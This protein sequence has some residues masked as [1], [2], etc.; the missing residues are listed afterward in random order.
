[1]PAKNATSYCIPCQTRRLDQIWPVEIY[2]N[3]AVI[4]QM[5]TCTSLVLHIA[6]VAQ[7]TFERVR[8]IAFAAGRN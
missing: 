5:V 1:M 4:A 3:V 7:F 8:R 6:V 2:A